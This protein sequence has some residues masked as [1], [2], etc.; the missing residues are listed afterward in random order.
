MKRVYDWSKA[1]LDGGFSADVQ[2]KRSDG[3]IMAQ[4][5]GKERMT[6]IVDVIDAT[7]DETTDT[8]SVRGMLVAVSLPARS[9]HITVPDGESYSGH[10]HEDFIE[11]LQMTVGRVYDA[12]IE[13][14]DTY[15]YA[16]E[17]HRVKNSLVQLLGPITVDNG[18]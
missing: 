10:F 1:N 14:I 9:F 3:R 2:W 5:V 18:S 17:Q 8:H 13:V 7:A 15:Q 12:Q 6:R 11:P 16:T 4:L